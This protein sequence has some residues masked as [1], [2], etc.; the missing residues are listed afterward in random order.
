MQAGAVDSAIHDQE[1]WA[2]NVEGY[3]RGLPKPGSMSEA[4]QILIPLD[5]CCDNKWVSVEHFKTVPD[6]MQKRIQNMF[7]LQSCPLPSSTAG[8]QSGGSAAA[9]DEPAQKSKQLQQR[10][11]F[12]VS[13]LYLGTLREETGMRETR[14]EWTEFTWL[15]ITYVLKII[16]HKS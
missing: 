7:M 5:Q 9:V 2:K 8:Q 6:H 3:V 16:N 13:S 11:I 10:W 12:R 14:V 15:L 1:Q 4:A